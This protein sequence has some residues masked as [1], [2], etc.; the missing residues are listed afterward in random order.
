MNSK[1]VYFITPTRVSQVSRRLTRLV[2]KPGRFLGK[3]VNTMANDALAPYVARSS[4]AM[5]LTM[6]DTRALVSHEGGKGGRKHEDI[7]RFP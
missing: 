2:P 7:F 5:M 6:L 3:K 4:V 1:N